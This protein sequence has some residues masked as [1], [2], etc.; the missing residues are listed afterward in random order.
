MLYISE[1]VGRGG[2]ESPEIDIAVDPLE[3]PSSAPRAP[4]T[5]L[6]FWQHRSEAGFSTTPTSTWIRPSSVP[7]QREMLISMLQ[8]RTI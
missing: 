7:P 6:Q 5:R 8:S 2:P 1:R 4:S 3:E